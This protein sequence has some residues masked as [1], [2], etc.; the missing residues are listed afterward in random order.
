M[1]YLNKL[2][3]KREMNPFYSGNPERDYD[4]YVK[5]TEYISERIKEET[6]REKIL[7]AIGYWNERNIYLLNN[8]EKLYMDFPRLKEKALHSVEIN[9][10]CISRAKSWL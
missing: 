10:K 2:K 1:N 8:I 3:T 4:N 7:A 9:S 6:R 5:N